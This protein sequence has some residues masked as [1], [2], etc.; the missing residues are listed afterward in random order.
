MDVEDIQ[1]I[2]EKKFR[3]EILHPLLKSIEGIDEIKEVHG[4]NENGK[5]FVFR[6][7]N[8]FGENTWKG[9]Q[10]KVGPINGGSSGNIGNLIEQAELALEMKY[11]YDYEG[12]DEYLS[13]IYIVTNGKITDSAS[14]QI[15]GRIHNRLKGSVYFVDGEK[16]IELIDKNMDTEKMLLYDLMDSL[17]EESLGEF[18]E[19]HYGAENAMND[20]GI[21][22]E[23][24]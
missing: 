23:V 24:Q 6:T 16:V 5:D 15:K 2:S 18:M 4:V 13:E 12:T 8:E 1:D 21:K 19:E 9:L 14:N 22:G 3:E 20:V 7:E 11:H 17:K 10:A